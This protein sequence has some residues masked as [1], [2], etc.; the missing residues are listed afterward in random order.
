M[1]ALGTGTKQFIKT[2]EC[3]KEFTVYPSTAAKKH[4]SA[5]CSSKFI[6]RK[7]RTGETVGC[8]V[9]G[10]EFYRKP[11]EVRKGAG[12]FCST[13]C[14]NAD[15]S[16]PPV[17]K[18]C[19]W[20]GKEMRLKPSQAERMHC[21]NNCY[22]RAKTTSAVIG[23]EHNGKSVRRNSDGYL[24]IWE[25]GQGWNGWLLEHRYV[26]AQMLGRPL[27]R[28]EQVDHI[29][30]IR[31]DNRPENLQILSATDHSV[32]TVARR[33]AEIKHLKDEL[34]EYRRRYGPLT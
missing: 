29:N 24:L 21:D 18:Q 34:E 30:R 11:T 27:T 8:E 7:R 31:D 10:N 2:C 28:D 4:C 6:P 13:A 20:C 19:V 14:K 25:P 22:G 15:Q 33:M 23:R 1:P 12:R 9:C 32:I 26:A 3:G 17:I 16:K 5:A